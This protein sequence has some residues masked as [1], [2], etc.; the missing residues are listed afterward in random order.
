MK[1]FLTL[2]TLFSL[3]GSVA[4]PYRPTSGREPMRGPILAAP[5]AA[6]AESAIPQESRYLSPLEEWS[7]EGPI[8]E[9]EFTV[10]FAW[11]NRQVFIHIG[12]A[13][14]E[15]ELFVN[16]KSA[17]Y[18]SD[19]NY[20][21]EFNVTKLAREGKNRLSLHFTVPSE[22][23]VLESWKQEPASAFD[24]GYVYSQPTMYIRDV[25]V[26]N[27]AVDGKPKAEVGIV[28]RT[29]G[30]NPKTSRI[31]YD[32]RTPDSTRIASGHQDLTLG[33]RGED[34]I[35]FVVGI[36]DSL[37]WSADRPVLCDLRLKT[38]YEGRYVEYLRIPLGFRIV[39]MQQGRVLVNGVPVE[40]RIREIAS[41]V[42]ASD[43]A[44]LK[45]DGWNAVKLRAGAVPEGFYAACDTLGIYVAVQAPIDT[46]K[47]GKDIRK[48]GNP[49]NDPEWL[50][51]YLER[52]SDSYH[53]VK[54]HPSV[55]AFSLAEE[56]AN[57]INLYESYLILKRMGD[58]RPVMYPDAGGEW[59]SDPLSF[60][61][62]VSTGK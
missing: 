53:S 50:P 10:P 58:S 25:T 4:Q 7:V 37:L 28:V 1:H 54:R 39:E 43:I 26:K 56:S 47:S 18:N 61:S 17:G 31:Y 30:L 5:S 9:S 15:Y 8:R 48:G 14:T 35:R 59:N 60:D 42:S 49:S 2:I 51:A 12:P 22:L 40:F 57:G 32:L 41:T 36:P 16:G 46:R 23:A 19:P 45:K 34:T 13:S 21:A 27:W 62:D 52:T 55:V 6:E 38:Q 11:A 33:M 3:A 29:A 20:P 44:G 24:G